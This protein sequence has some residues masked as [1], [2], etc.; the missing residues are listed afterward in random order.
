M[1][2]GVEAEPAHA[3]FFVARLQVIPPAGVRWVDHGERAQA[4]TVGPHLLGEFL[5]TRLCVSVS[6]GMRARRRPDRLPSRPSI[7][8]APSGI[9]AQPA[10]GKVTEVGIDVDDHAFRAFRIAAIFPP[11]TLSLS[12]A[13]SSAAQIRPTPAVKDM[14]HPNRSRSTPSVRAAIFTTPSSV[15]L[16]LVSR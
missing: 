15:T 16:P 1:P 14:S 13:L 2:P 10:E 4:V 11:R 3:E 8:R 6:D 7:S 9:V 5:V 12:A